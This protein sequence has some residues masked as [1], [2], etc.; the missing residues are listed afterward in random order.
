[1]DVFSGNILGKGFAMGLCNSHV[2]KSRRGA[3]GLFPPKAKNRSASSANRL[4]DDFDSFRDGYCGCWGCGVAGFWSAPPCCW[5]S[6]CF[7]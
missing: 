4:W 5:L 7:S 6:S 1:M 2:W 3:P